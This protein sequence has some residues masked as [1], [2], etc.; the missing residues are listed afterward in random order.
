[1]VIGNGSSYSRYI[2][3]CY[4]LILLDATFSAETQ[5]EA[6]NKKIEVM[7]ERLDMYEKI[8]KKLSCQNAELLKIIS[9]KMEAEGKLEKDTVIKAMTTKKFST[10][11][12][13]LDELI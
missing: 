5:L 3:K 12:A 13:K 1:M 4:S 8:I 11:R 10:S 7:E 2:K 9:G 6:N